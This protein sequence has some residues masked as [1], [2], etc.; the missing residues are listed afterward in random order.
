MMIIGRQKTLENECLAGRDE[1]REI[2]MQ[3]EKFVS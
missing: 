1:I 2:E 3:M